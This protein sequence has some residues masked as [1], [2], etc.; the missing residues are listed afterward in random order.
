[1]PPAFTATGFAP[2]GHAPIQSAAKYRA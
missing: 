2:S 1:M